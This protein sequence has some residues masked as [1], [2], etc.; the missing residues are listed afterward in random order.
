ML[1]T[2]VISM[3]KLHFI[4][5]T[6][7]I[8]STVYLYS[9]SSNP[10]QKDLYLV[11]V[12]VWFIY[13]VKKSFLCLGF[14]SSLTTAEL[15]CLV[16]VRNWDVPIVVAIVVDFGIQEQ[17]VLEAEAIARLG[18]TNVIMQEGFIPPDNSN[19]FV[20]V[21]YVVTLTLTLS[22]GTLQ[23]CTLLLSSLFCSELSGPL[24]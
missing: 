2:T 5:E 14:I 1:P 18:L 9:D 8:V 7:A 15:S 22:N 4:S 12:V 10:R 6:K 11:N 21:F 23:L 24:G 17:L 20:N 16:A 19:G 3:I 13:S